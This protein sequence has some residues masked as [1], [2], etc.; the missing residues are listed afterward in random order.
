MVQSRSPDKGMFKVWDLPLRLFHWSLLLLF[1]IAYVTGSRVR[2]YAV[3]EA[4]GIALFGLLIFRLIWGFI[5]SEPARFSSF[6]KGPRAVLSHVRELLQRRAEPLP[7]HNPLGG[8]GV[9]VMLALLVIESISGLFSSTFDYAGPLAPL[10]LDA[11]ADRMASI[12][13]INLNLLLGMI[14]LHLLGVALTSFFGRENLVA[15]MIHG[16]KHLAQTSG[17]P[18][19]G[20]SGVRVVIAVLVAVAIAGG[21]FLLGRFLA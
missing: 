6:L 2:Y 13:A 14:G 15:S 7:G 17:V 20:G 10:V 9:A 12:H 1:L 8:W 5:G 16:R 11:W 4:A 3:H 18:V 21:L 19:Q